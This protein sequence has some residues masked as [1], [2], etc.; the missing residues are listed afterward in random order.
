MTD[1]RLLFE[2]LPGLYLILSPDLNIVAVNDAY[3]Q[4][5]LTKRESIVGRHL[6]DVFP[7]NPGDPNADGVR[8]LH[9]SLKRVVAEKTADAMAVQKYDIRR[10]D[11]AGGGFEERYWSPVNSP[12]LSSAGELVAI[13]HRAEDVTEFV[14][15][16]QQ[17]HEQLKLN[18]ELRTRAGQMEAEV[19]QRAKEVQ[20]GNE[21]LREANTQLAKR[22]R[23][24]TVLYERL[25]EQNR[26]IQAANRMKSE[27]LANMSHELRTPLN[28]IIGFSELLS[29]GVPGPVN[30][31]Q[32]EYLEH[33]LTSG[34]HLLSLIND[35]LDLAKVEAGKMEV[36]PELTDVA[37]LVDEVRGVLRSRASERRIQVNVEVEPG[38]TGLLV[39]PG[40][41]KQ[42]LYNYLSNAL[43]FTPLEGTVTVRARLEGDQEFRIE[44]VDSGIGI[45][46][47]DMGKLFT[48]FQQLESGMDKKYGGTGLGLV[49]TK[50]MVE[51][52]GGRVGA[53]ST[54]GQGSV[55]FA[56]LPREV[57]GPDGHAELDV[58][59]RE[60]LPAPAAG[61]SSTSGNA[62]TVLVVED[63]SEDRAWLVR[64]LTE[65]GYAVETA[66]DGAEALARCKERAYD[67]ITMDIL[68]PD[69]SGLK[70][71][72]GIREQG[73]NRD[74]PVIVVS[75]V[76]D[77]QLV[78]GFAVWDVLA[79]PAGGPE[80]LVALQGAGVLA[81]RQRRV[82]VVDDDRAALELMRAL[83][84]D[85]GYSP[86]CESEA[87]TA[88]GRV[89]VHA[90]AAIVLDLLMPGM[91]GF[92][93][94]RRLRL[95][96]DGQ[97]IPVLV[98]T[99]K[100]LS[101]EE[102]NR[103]SQSAQGVMAK[104][105]EGRDSLLRELQHHMKLGAQIDST[106]RALPTA[107]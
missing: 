73:P 12:L 3:L 80:L 103:L 20:A 27:F 33:V 100:D 58:V 43:K 91:D 65:A 102:R 86:V 35:V 7:D 26:L 16:K 101:H 17:G 93:F 6:F 77:K 98:W 69:M 55:F 29:D 83:L 75:V 61:G 66:A 1:Y 22:E 90:P 19:L 95:D 79:K 57:K 48:E 15:L 44:V 76:A 97:R 21:Q 5:T 8:N 9:A 81:G 50:R 63:G 34:R 82:M 36:R 10:P 105:T 30:K 88:L 74:T 89:A 42:V 52:Q 60:A 47:E 85:L 37:A 41:L 68:L 72:H 23:E 104:G 64:T 46:P 2:S 31:A 53:R 67:A 107:E 59:P 106:A 96:P 32:K 28:A 49:L 70:V 25:V 99:S 13:V 40:K 94:L 18:D 51:A 24:R 62:C 14:R 78:T 92:E 45:R 39:D 4:A 54:V 11:S 71:L 84:V 87:E 38:L 56:I